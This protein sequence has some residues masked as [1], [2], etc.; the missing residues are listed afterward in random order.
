[1]A[2]RVK[3]RVTK[4]CCPVCEGTGKLRLFNLDCSGCEGSGRMPTKGVK[5]YLELEEVFSA[6]RFIVDGGSA[7]DRSNDIAR[8]QKIAKLAGVRAP[9]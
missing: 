2:A 1:M 9:R 5:E 8:M 4:I 7:D 6:G 3:L